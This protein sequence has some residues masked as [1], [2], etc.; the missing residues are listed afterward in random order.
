MAMAAPEGNYQASSSSQAP[1]AGGHAAQPEAVP[2]D[3][4]AVATGQH[5]AK[6]VPTKKLSKSGDVVVD[7]KA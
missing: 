4:D 6:H 1:S 7:R 3:E 5:D 2:F